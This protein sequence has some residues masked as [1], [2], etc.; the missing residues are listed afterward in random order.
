VSCVLDSRIATRR[1]ADK[2]LPDLIFVKNLFNPYRR[3][4]MLL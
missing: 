3:L 4:E 1:R 2:L